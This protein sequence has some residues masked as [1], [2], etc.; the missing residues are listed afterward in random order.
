LAPLAQA[1]QSARTAKARAEKVQRTS[2]AKIEIVLVAF[3]LVIFTVAVVSAF[4]FLSGRWR[5]SDWAPARPGRA[6]RGD[7]SGAVGVHDAG[8]CIRHPRC[9]GDA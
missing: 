8:R 7:Q 5:L 3:L 1:A 6:W 9:H 2:R 4:A